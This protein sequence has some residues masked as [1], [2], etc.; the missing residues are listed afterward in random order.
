VNIYPAE[1]E[2]A[3]IEH[4]DVDDCAV[5]AME[6][7]LFGEVPRAVVQPAAGVAPGARLT[8]ELL[9][10]LG[11][12]LA[13]MKLPHRIDYAEALPRDTNGKLVRRQLPRERER[14]R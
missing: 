5:V 6:H 7:D 11:E 8:V 14:G 3:L 12:R 4:R 13:P 1:I 9:R 10:F 2:Q